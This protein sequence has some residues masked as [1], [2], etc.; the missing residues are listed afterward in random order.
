[1]NIVFV[2]T[3]LSSL[4]CVF[5]QDAPPLISGLGDISTQAL[6]NE[7]EVIIEELVVPPFLTSEV[8]I[9]IYPNL[10]IYYCHI[11]IYGSN[12]HD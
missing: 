4:L 6:P 8:N 5:G 1:M 7:D 11:Y 9:L 2:F 10:Y 3:L 12:I